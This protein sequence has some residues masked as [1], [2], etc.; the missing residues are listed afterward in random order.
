MAIARCSYYLHQNFKTLKLQ[1]THR[2]HLHADTTFVQ[3]MYGKRIWSIGQQNQPFGAKY[4]TAQHKKRFSK[5]YGAKSATKYFPWLR[6]LGPIWRRGLEPLSG[7]SPL[8]ASFWSLI[9]GLF[10]VSDA[11]GASFCGLSCLIASLP[12][13]LSSS[14]QVCTVLCKNWIATRLISRLDGW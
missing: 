7:V 8:V 4:R 2:N 10:L 3:W 1:G 13:T 12:L 6:K 9:C 14:W 5:D 11:E